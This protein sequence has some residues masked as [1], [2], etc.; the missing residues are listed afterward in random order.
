MLVLTGVPHQAEFIVRK[1]SQCNLTRKELR[2]CSTYGKDDG[3]GGQ[4]F[5]Q[6]RTSKNKSSVAHIVY[7]RMGKLEVDEDERCVQGE[8]TWKFLSGIKWAIRGEHYLGT[9]SR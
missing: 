9:Q 2:S 3:P 5:S 7:A 1:Y 8:Y 6:D 4:D